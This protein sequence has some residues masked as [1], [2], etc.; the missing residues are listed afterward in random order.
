MFTPIYHMPREVEQKLEKKGADDYAAKLNEENRI[1]NMKK[2]AAQK[3]EMAF[4][5]GLEAGS[6]RVIP[7]AGLAPV[8]GEIGIAP[9]ASRQEVEE[10]VSYGD[11][12]AND[13]QTKAEQMATHVADVAM[14]NGIDPRD[15]QSIAGIVGQIFQKELSP[16]VMQA[17]PDKINKLGNLVVQLATD[18]LAQVALVSG[19]VGGLAQQGQAMNPQGAQQ[20]MQQQEPMAPEGGSAGLVT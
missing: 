3:E 1:N 11:K 15:Q 17:N 4:M 9:G 10:P 20:G 13:I 16:E 14:K 7:E 8:G 18:E 12:Q 2:E 19:Q 5:T 6:K